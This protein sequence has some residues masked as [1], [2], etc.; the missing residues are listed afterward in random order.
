MRAIPRQ[1]F[2]DKKMKINTESY[3]Q[4]S[5]IKTILILYKSVGTFSNACVAVIWDKNKIADLFLGL[6]FT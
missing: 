2:L 4:R 5:A 1:V 6:F 3:I